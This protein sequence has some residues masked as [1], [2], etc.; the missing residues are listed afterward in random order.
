MTQ[1]MFADL[2]IK[3]LDDAHAG[4]TRNG[5]DVSLFIFS[6]TEFVITTGLSPI[7]FAGTF[8]KSESM[9]SPREVVVYPQ[10]VKFSS[11]RMTC[12]ELGKWINDVGL[13]VGAS[14]I[15]IRRWP[16]KINY[17]KAMVTEAVVAFSRCRADELLLSKKTAVWRGEE[18]VIDG[19]VIE[20]DPAE[21]LNS[22]GADVDFSLRSWQADATTKPRCECGVTAVGGPAR[23]PQHSH[24][25][26]MRSE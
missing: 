16:T 26:P 5:P 12:D 18:V 17:G 24:W 19:K 9:R 7:T 10:M 14:T 4:S 8:L 1:R 15:H 23:G 2:V 25:C 21:G 11:S 22:S 6:V 3:E 20:T 13:A